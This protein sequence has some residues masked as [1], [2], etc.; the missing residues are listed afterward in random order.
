MPG[1]IGVDD[2]RASK[3]TKSPMKPFQARGNHRQGTTK[4][5]HTR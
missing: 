3:Q 1:T 4:P 2:K 5:S